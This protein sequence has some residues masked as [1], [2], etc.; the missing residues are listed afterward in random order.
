MFIRKQRDLVDDLFQLPK[1]SMA[2]YIQ[3]TLNDPS[4]LGSVKETEEENIGKEGKRVYSLHDLSK[5]L[6]KL[7]CRSDLF[8]RKEQAMPKISA[9]TQ[10]DV[11][12]SIKESESEYDAS[13]EE[14]KSSKSTPRISEDST[15][16]FDKTDQVDSP[17]QKMFMAHK[18]TKVKDVPD[19]IQEESNDSELVGEHPECTFFKFFTPSSAKPV[20][21][22]TSRSSLYR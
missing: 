6:R 4:D 8:E 13:S 15:L 18:K 22:R 5:D 10:G 3:E 12:T 17:G 2:D 7:R 16:M 21:E 20:A 19:T 9:V 11:D 14:E 1:I